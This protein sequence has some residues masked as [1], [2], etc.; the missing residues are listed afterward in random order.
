MGGRRSI[1]WALLLIGLGVVLLLR[2]ADVIPSDVD[3]WPILVFAL[4]VWL[5]VERIL[6]RER[7]LVVPLVLIAIGVVFFLQQANVVSSGL[8][9]WPVI[10]IAVGVGIVLSALPLGGRGAAT[11]HPSIPL[12][13]AAAGRVVVKHGAGRLWVRSTR[14]PEALVDGS[15]SGGVEPRERRV[16]DTMEVTL[17]RR[18]WRPRTGWGP[19]DWE[20]GITRRVPVSLELDAG[21]NRAELDLSDLTVPDLRVNTGASETSI[22]LPAHGRTRAV[23]VC[24]A[25]SVRIR[26]PERT[27]ARIAV[28]A[29]VMSVRVDETRFPKG[30][31]GYRS[32]D[33]D[34]AGD[35]IDLSIEG[36]AASVEVR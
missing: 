30:V 27:P 11:T 18:S 9:V 14:D 25:A 34:D 7:D 12:G 33:F 5:L 28:R 21:A 17:E 24:G 1:A 10:L 15:F 19:M 29:G 3:W 36:G 2:E 20:V 23:V 26:V 31:D 8:T 16:G 35:G 22:T 32:S 13:G 4:G 6:S